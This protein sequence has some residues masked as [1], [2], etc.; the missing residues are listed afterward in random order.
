MPLYHGQLINVSYDETKRYAGIKSNDL[1][2]E[3]SIQNALLEAQLLAKPQGVYEIYSYN[4][5]NQLIQ[6]TPP[7]H[8][9]GSS[10]TKHLAN[11]SHAAIMAVTI[12][13][14]VETTI[15]NHFSTGNYQAGLLLD[16]AATATVES[17][18]DQ[19][20]RLIDSLAAKEGYATTW[21]FSPGY[22]NWNITI[23]R[24][25][26]TALHAETIGLTVTESFM[27]QPRKSITAAIGLRS[28]E[29]CQNVMPQ[30]P[31]A[32]CAQKNCLARKE[33]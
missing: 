11:C 33:I 7:L 2:P 27:L 18:A 1:F 19:V 28:K 10:I 31:C 32:T 3:S 14:Q 30:P 26:L 29:R 16:A 23:Q 24:N 25:L 5:L 17:I 12:G 8:L 13:E 6:S 4:E 22:G 21:R 9:L 20:N 15:T